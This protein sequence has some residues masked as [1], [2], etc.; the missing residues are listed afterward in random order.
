MQNESFESKGIYEVL[1]KG[2]Y[3]SELF[4]RRSCWHA[5]C[6]GQRIQV[7]LKVMRPSDQVLSIAPV[8]NEDSECLLAWSS[9][10]LSKRSTTLDDNDVLGDFFL[11]FY[12]GDWTA[13]N[14]A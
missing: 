7:Y 4:T 10:Q 12:N 3:N 9:E 11:L 13:F 1:S 5:N 2:L 14:T 8:E 6:A